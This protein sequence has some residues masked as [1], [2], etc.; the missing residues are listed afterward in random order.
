MRTLR[1]F[2]IASK[3]VIIFKP[4]RDDRYAKDKIV[5]HNGE[6]VKAI[7][8]AKAQDL[9]EHLN[10]GVN[11]GIEVVGIDEVQFFDVLELI[12]VAKELANQGKKIIMAALDQAASGQPFPG[13][14]ELLVEA[15]V[16]K[17]LHAVCSECGNLASRTHRLGDSRELIEVGGI[18]K[19]QP[20]CRACW[21]KLNQD[22]LNNNRK[23]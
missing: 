7:V 22:R 20:L 8:V 12:E 16:I 19:Y 4:S 5:T 9:L 14:A 18:E 17:K 23:D 11:K 10:Q 13:M 21:F 15:D 6:E 3:Q 1:R 2:K